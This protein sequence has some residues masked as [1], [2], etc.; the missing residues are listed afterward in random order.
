MTTSLR[1]FPVRGLVRRALIP[2]CALIPWLTVSSPAAAQPAQRDPGSGWDEVFRSDDAAYVRQPNSFL[3]RCVERMIRE[4]LTKAGS[5]ALVLAMGDGRNAVHLAVRGFEVTGIDISAFSIPTAERAAAASGVEIRT[6]RGD[7]FSY[8]LGDDAWDLVTNIYFNPSIKMI[9][10]IKRA[11]RPGGL[12]VI[13]GFGADYTGPG[14]PQWSR[15]EA[16]QLLQEL[17]GWRI[18]EYQDGVFASDWAA[19][20]PVPVVR[21]LARKPALRPDESSR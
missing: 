10:R 6:V 3:D 7:L 17:D 13:E 8:D 5:T 12:L 2:F 14:P 20:R 1:P 16:N 15:Y 18:L 4:G 21:L 11:V 19:G 9:D